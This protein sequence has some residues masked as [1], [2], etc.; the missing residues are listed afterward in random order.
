LI[1]PER[2]YQAGRITAFVM[3]TAVIV[4]AVLSPLRAV[5]AMPTFIAYDVAVRPTATTA[6]GRHDAV[7]AETERAPTAR[8]ATF[9]Y[10]DSLNR[11]NA[12]GVRGVLTYDNALKLAE[13]REMTEMYDTFSA[14]TAAEGGVT[15]TQE[16]LATVTNH[17][18]QF[19]EHAPNTAM[20]GRLTSQVGSAVTGADAN[21]YTHEL[22]EAG[23]MAS[24]MG[25]DAQQ[26]PAEFNNAWRAFW[27]LQ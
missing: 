27:G 3:L 13:P 1:H 8:N 10:D 5:A 11:T 22:L 23:H 6:L 18:A 20:L 24:G 25:Y 7:R 15:V 12:A 19:G 16:G 14:T 9:T 26:F 21:F 4:G 2:P 17:L